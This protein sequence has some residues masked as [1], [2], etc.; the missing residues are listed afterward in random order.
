MFG[1]RGSKFST[2]LDLLSL[3]SSITKDSSFVFIFLSAG[4]YSVPRSIVFDLSCSDIWGKNNQK[5]M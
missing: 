2:L 1:L 3:F 5:K 4:M